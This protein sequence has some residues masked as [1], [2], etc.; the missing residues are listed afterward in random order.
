MYTCTCCNTTFDIPTDI[1]LDAVFAD[2]DFENNFFLCH[3]CYEY[4]QGINV[5][6]IQE[7]EE[8]S[9]YYTEEFADTI[10]EFYELEY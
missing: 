4:L 2:Y 3:T 1:P 6:E 8:Y 9:E 10:H 5:F 7:I